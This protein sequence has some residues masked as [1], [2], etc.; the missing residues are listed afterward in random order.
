[1]WQSWDLRCRQEPWGDGGDME[2][3]KHTPKHRPTQ[4]SVL[5]GQEAAHG[6]SREHGEVDLC[7][8]SSGCSVEDET[9]KMGHDIQEQRGEAC[10]ASC[11]VT[12]PALV[13]PG[14]RNF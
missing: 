6:F 9:Q 14:M 11:E 3:R 10:H 4:H 2:G 12:L 7:A 1:M 5:Y 13:P 8:H